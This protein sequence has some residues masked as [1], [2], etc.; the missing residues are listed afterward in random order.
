MFEQVLQKLG[1]SPN[2][3]KVYE[4]LLSFDSAN[5][6][7]IAV[8][9]KVHR[10]NVYDCINKLI[11]KGLVSELS[12]ENEKHYKA[13]NPNRLI[14]LLKEKEDLLMGKLP[15]M[16]KKFQK[17][18]A[19]EQAYVY[20]GIQGFKNYLQD[21]LDQG[22]DVYCIASK[23]G[24]GDPRL[25]PFTSRFYKQLHKKG[26]KV[27]NLFDY[28]MKNEIPKF[29]TKRKIPFKVLPKGY[30]SD[31]AID[32]FGNHIVTFTGLSAKK[33]EEDLTLF[34]IISPKL[35]NSYRNWFKMIWN[36][37]PGDKLE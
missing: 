11:E 33:L 5:V 30:S 15:L 3:A 36:L 14:A 32:I 37:L 13:I 23:N 26:I 4:T 7:T 31:S 6:S 28:E 19:K 1:L 25:E 27:F 12:L 8:K 2:E 22:E 18:E 16:Q 35:S 21:I 9:S 20:K 34:V 24:W 17:I 29:L 10:R